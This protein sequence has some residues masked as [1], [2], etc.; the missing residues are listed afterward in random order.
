L[1][2]WGFSREVY[3]PIRWY[4]EP[5]ACPSYAEQARQLQLSIALGRDLT[6]S[7]VKSVFG[8]RS[9]PSTSP[10]GASLEPT[11]AKVQKRLQIVVDFL[12]L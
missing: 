11:I 9:R 7:A 6:T 12:R 3:E 5:D 10:K 4:A 2:Y 1:D 8:A